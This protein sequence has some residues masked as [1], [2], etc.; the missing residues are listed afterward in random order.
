MFIPAF[1][2]FLRH[3]LEPYDKPWC[4]F[5]FFFSPNFFPC[6][7]CCVPRLLCADACDVCQN[8]SNML[9]Y[10]MKPELGEYLDVFL[11]LQDPQF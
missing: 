8:R 4:W 11:V 3:K 2:S 6:S 10:T 1:G 9:R 7:A 5:S